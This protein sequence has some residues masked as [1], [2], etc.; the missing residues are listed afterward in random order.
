[1]ANTK[2]IRPS[3]LKEWKKAHEAKSLRRRSTTLNNVY[4]GS[5]HHSRF[6]TAL[7]DQ[8][9]EVEVGLLRKSRFLVEFDEVDRTLTLARRLLEGDLYGG[10]APV[11]SQALT[12]CARIL[13]ATDNLD[14]AE[15]FLEA[16][17]S[18]GA[19]TRIVDA[20][21]CS[22]KGDKCSALDALIGIDS[23]DSLTAAF[24]VVAH[25]DGPQGA[26]DWLRTAGKNAS[27][28][29][30]DGKCILLTN[31][32]R[33]GKWEVARETTNALTESD[34]EEVPT[35][36]YMVAMT[37]LLSTVPE[38][39]RDVVLNHVPFDAATFPLASDA[40]AIDARRIARTHFINA[41]KAVQKLNYPSI[42][43]IPDGYALWLELR[44]SEY[45]DDGK[46][47]LEDRLSDLE[48][49]L[50]F[51]PLGL[52]FDIRLDQAVVEKEIERT[53]RP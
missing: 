16:A 32:V 14:K 17:K 31:L 46:L 33:L 47:R 44:D 45:F 13:S 30:P 4:S 51:V 9:I 19:D 22:R 34:F 37:Y 52:Q 6:P 36:H 25:H 23:P 43:A 21:I 40:T 11:S 38:E 35:L 1:M 48:S 3:L 41:V 29:D 49:A 12:W 18:L 8:N 42:A 5:L 27:D 39:R 53:H 10:S 28:L 15:E 2:P 7:V 50:H 26:I 20:L 24:I